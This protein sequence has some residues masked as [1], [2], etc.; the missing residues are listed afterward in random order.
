MK[1]RGAIMSKIMFDSDILIDL[2]REI[3]E[4]IAFFNGINEEIYISVVSKM[5]LLRGCRNKSEQKTTKIFLDD[6]TMLPVNSEESMMACDLYS[7]F[8]LSHGV[9]ILDCFIAASAIS[10]H[11]IL[12]T[13]NLKHLGIFPDIDVREPY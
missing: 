2:A 8:H 10:L 3:P 9:T 1:N 12:Y 5:E 7:Q 4:C 11:L 6:F 13:K